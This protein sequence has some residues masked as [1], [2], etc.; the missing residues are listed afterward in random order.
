MRNSSKRKIIKE[1]EIV[2]INNQNQSFNAIV[3]NI[4]RL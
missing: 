2:A 1:N 4:I 3:Y